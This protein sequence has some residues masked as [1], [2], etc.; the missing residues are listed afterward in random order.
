MTTRPSVARQ[1]PQH[2]L[3]STG[4]TQRPPP[5]RAPSQQFSSSS[6]TRRGNESFVDLTFEGGDAARPR[7]GNSRLRV[8][9]STDPRQS[10]IKSPKSFLAATPPRGRPQL[11]FDVP[12]AGQ[13]GAQEGGQHAI[14]IKP[15]PLP[16]R[17]GQHA[18]PTS[19]KPRPVPTSTTAKKDARPKPYNLEVPAIAPHYSPNGHADFYPWTGNHPE[20]QFSETAIRQGYF[21][22]S[23]TSQNETGS[24]RSTIFPAL[25][26]KSGLQTLSAIFTNVLAQRRAHGQI[27]SGSTFK[28]PPRVTVTDTKRE[29]WLRDLANPT[30]SLR[31][32]S[33]S[34]PHGIR[35]K[36]LLDQSL[37]KNIPI[38]RAVWL[39]KCVGANELRSFRRKGAS[40]T[41]AMGGEAKWIRDFTVCVEQFLETIIGTC[42][43]K[44]F[45]ARIGYAIRLATNFHAEY[46]LD[47]E[48]YM[49]WLVSSL[50]NS[51]Q[52]KLPM[53]LLVTQI[54]WKDLL[55][56]RKYGRRLVASLMN[57]LAETL[58]DPDHDLMAPLVDRLKFLLNGLMTS[59]IHNFVSPKVWNT[60]RDILMA[61]LGSEDLLLKSVL[62]AIDRRNSRFIAAGASKEPN[63][64]QRLITLL[65]GTLFKPSSTDLP[66]LCWDIDNDKELLVSTVLEW[67]ASSHRPGHAKIYVAARIL[68]FW[69]K[70]DPDVTGSILKFLDSSI[71]DSIRCKSAFY[72]LVSE[73][74]RSEHFSMPRYLQW[75][76]ARGGIYSTADLD[77]HGPASTRLLAELPT[78]NVSDSIIELRAALLG[79]GDLSADEEDDQVHDCMVFMNRTLPGMQTGDD[80]DLEPNEYSATSGLSKLP[81]DLS[82]TIRSEL[83]LWLRQKVKLQMVQSTIPPLD[84]WDVSLLKGGTSAMTGSEFNTVRRYLEYLEDY[85]MLADV[86]KIATTSNDAEVLASCADTLDLH[87]ETF[88]AIG[89]LNSLFDILMSRL[90][91]LTEENVSVLRTFLVSLSDLASRLPNQHTVAQQ[92][93]QELARSDRKTAADACSPVSDHM[94]IVETAE[95]DFTDEI[96]KVLASGNSMDQATLERLFGRIILRL[97][98]SWEKSPE[99]Q[100]SCALL[101]TRLRAFDAKQFDLL[102]A[103]W[104]GKALPMQSRPNMMQVFG[105]LISFGCLAFRDV[106][107]GCG[108]SEKEATVGSS[109]ATGTSSELLCLLV[110]PF[111]LPEIMTHE[112]TYRLRVK[113]SHM[114]KDFPLDVTS[115]IRQAFAESYSGTQPAG[116]HAL[117]VKT[118]LGGVDMH[119]L[120]QFLVLHDPV[121]FT[122]KLAVPL[123]QTSTAE[124]AAAINTVIDKLMLAGSAVEPITTELLLN[125]TDDLSLPFCQI[126]LASMLQAH[127]TT[128]EGGEAGQPDHL[129]AFDSAI[130]S[131]VNSGKISWA[132]IIPL[133][134][135][136]IAQHLRRRADI[137]F[138]SLF[139]SPK[140]PNNEGFLMENRITRAE[141]L[142]RIIDATAHSIST[143]SPDPS[144]TS[145]A[146][147]MVTTL[148][149]TRLLLANT[150]SQEVKDIVISKWLPL[151][152]SFMTIHVSAFEATKQGNESRAKAT[153][154]L[155]AVFLQL[156]AIDLSTQAIVTLV[157][158]TFD[159]ALNLVDSLPEDLRLQCVRSIRTT[160][161]NPQIPYLFSIAAN[162]TEWLVLSQKEKAPVIPGQSNPDGNGRQVEKEKLTPFH[163]RRWELLGEPTPNV[164][165]NDTSLSLTLFGAR[166]G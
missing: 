122:Q 46:L 120:Y 150:Q 13:R 80:L 25:K 89:A 5:L 81:S 43:E 30:I 151:L 101:L 26:H 138:L 125:I 135:I 57:Q 53:W 20:D 147:D 156:Q 77:P 127:D 158:Q 47:R 92:L 19:E 82:R 94:A 7:L 67:A 39:A 128:M 160:T 22:K 124:T 136:S 166:R 52:T 134:D 71:C 35:G 133:L 63:S 24:A 44:D 116:S 88:A 108:A 137:Q 115:V 4:P 27:T 17:P 129:V 153:L 1:P 31:R 45:R 106:L 109:Y 2:S 123:L 29:M 144:N 165:E 74:A 96:E 72:H 15:M 159:L 102:M 21:D 149:G 97:Q 90:R 117:E 132:S 65:D 164:G 98:E 60:H 18:P 118:L 87:L 51:P 76:I 131:A 105:P 48:H 75:L 61:N 28:P 37:S 3:S 100:R 111:N 41:F 145:L 119:E 110:A 42:G 154:A 84:D 163:L 83:G 95:V 85:S 112:E 12:S 36:V 162:P 107:L 155:A 78:A 103:A 33:R 91:A 40:G 23:H 114:Q 58:N 113:Q 121:A 139:P 56:F 38:E 6:P 161:S 14:T 54:Y 32:L 62:G 104:V 69:S 99:Q 152:L 59:N 142:L 141:N 148:N 66:R 68:R 86:L 64:R 16:V 11:P 93:A 49:D 70:N 130:E 9:I 55:K 34:I 8:E 50:E 146:S 73:L 157:E 79:R 140:T 126:K 10:D 143:S